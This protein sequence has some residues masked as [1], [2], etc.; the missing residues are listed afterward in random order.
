[1]LL[2][3]GLEV[4]GKDVAGADDDGANQVAE[5]VLEGRDSAPQRASSESGSPAGQTNATR[6][7]EAHARRG[8]ARHHKHQSGGCGGG[9]PLAADVLDRALQGRPARASDPHRKPRS[10]RQ[11]CHSLPLHM[12]HARRPASTGPGSR[13]VRILREGLPSRGRTSEPPR[14]TTQL[15]DSPYIQGEPLD[16]Q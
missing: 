12:R 7:G 9:Q 6:E 5:P 10:Q 2:L 14:T 15:N 1:M 8:G 4:V 16:Q 11:P 3:A 13:Q